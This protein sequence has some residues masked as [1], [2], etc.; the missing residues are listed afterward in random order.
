[1]DPM[2]RHRATKS[3]CDGDGRVTRHPCLL[4]PHED[5]D[6][7][8]GDNKDDATT[9]TTATTRMAQRQLLGLGFHDF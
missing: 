8:N 5:E 1:M 7:V 2:R 6:E 4:H 3:S 9:R